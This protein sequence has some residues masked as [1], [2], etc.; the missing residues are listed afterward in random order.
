LYICY[1]EEFFDRMVSHGLCAVAIMYSD[2]WLASYPTAHTGQKASEIFNEAL[3]NSAINVIKQYCVCNDIIV[4]GFSQ[5]AHISALAYNYNNNVRGVLMFSGGCQ[6]NFFDHCEELLKRTIPRSCIRDISSQHDT[7]LGCG[8]GDSGRSSTHQ[9][10]LMAGVDCDAPCSSNGSPVKTPNDCCVVGGHGDSFR[11]CP[12]ADCDHQCSCSTIKENCLTPNGGGYYIIMKDNWDRGHEWF[13]ESKQ[14]VWPLAWTT[15]E[16]WNIGAQLDW[17]VGRIPSSTT[18]PAR[19][20]PFAPPPHAA[21]PAGEDPKHSKG[22]ESTG[23]RE[24]HALGG[25][26]LLLILSVAVMSWNGSTFKMQHL[27]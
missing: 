14:K 26:I 8:W 2:W 6:A 22:W 24:E 7:T 1:Y 10:K 27:T 12:I 5:G 21:P 11:A 3:E 25:L 23:I 18:P 13:L 16:A 20:A 17:L 15:K 19:R 9:V 4:H